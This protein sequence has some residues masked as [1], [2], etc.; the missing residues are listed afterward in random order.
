MGVSFDLFGTL[1]S[2][3]K[4]ADPAAAVAAEL[5]A[6]DVTVPDDWADAYAEAHVD[7]PEGAEIPLPAHVSR[8]L[9]SRGVDFDGNAPRRAVV[10][11]FDPTVET[12]DGAEAAVE[13]ARDYG[14]V[15]ICSNC[16]VPELVGRTLVRSAFDRS[17]F[18]AIVTSVGCGWRKPAPQIFELTASHLET[19]PSNL[20]HIGD[21][22]DA[23]GGVETVDGTPLLLEEHPLETIPAALATRRSPKS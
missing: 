5:E 13:A 2:A 6:R 20:I 1:V 8:A 23:D 4:P 19:P 15:A 12:R 17:D 21:D 16:S 11:A 14:P 9:A 10:S 18:D 22:A 3:E 7:A